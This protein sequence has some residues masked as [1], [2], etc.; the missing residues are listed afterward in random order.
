ME[1]ASLEERMNRQEHQLEELCG[2]LQKLLIRSD[3]P[4]T[5]ST[6][7]TPSVPTEQNSSTSTTPTTRPPVS[8]ALPE[9]YDGSP[10]LCQGFLM[11]CSMF[12]EHHP[13]QFLTEIDKIHFVISLLTGKAKA[14]ASALF[15]QNSNILISETRFLD[16]FKAVFNHPLTGRDVGNSLCDIRQGKRSA[17]DYALEFRTLAAGSGWSKVALLTVYKRGLRRDLQAEMV[18]RGEQLTLDCFIQ[19]SIALD[20]LVRER[21]YLQRPSM[22]TP[23]TTALTPEAEPME[24]GSTHLSE[25]ERCRRLRENLCLYCGCT[26][27]R[28]A[29]CSQ[30]PSSSRALEITR[31]NYSYSRQTL[32]DINIH[33]TNIGFTHQFDF[34]QLPPE[35]IRTPGPSESPLPTGSARRRRRQRKQRRDFSVHIN[36]YS[37][38]FHIS[39]FI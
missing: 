23:V 15:T 38:F 28:L 5:A 7:T 14:W 21:S 4:H 2:M 36:S 25:T 33:C 39:Q 19:T 29:N 12:I 9:R 3:Q 37:D 16:S 34:N 31:A 35:L 10:D 13:E 20:G 30:R 24:L 8:I 18:C 6:P 32:L 11:Q 26:G 22:T 1:S 27:H 17:A